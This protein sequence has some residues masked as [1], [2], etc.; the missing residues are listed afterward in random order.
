MPNRLLPFPLGAITLTEGAAAALQS[1]KQSPEQLL[2]RHSFGDWGELD[3]EDW[4]RNNHALENAL[5]LLSAYRL[6]DNTKIW[7]ITEWDRSGTTVLLPDE[8]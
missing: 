6:R 4:E 7:V 5:R 2:A 3:D 8:Y 1:T